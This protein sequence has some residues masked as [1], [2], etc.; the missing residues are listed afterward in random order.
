MNHI[1]FTGK[2]PII[3]E[4]GELVSLIARTDLK[5]NIAYPLSSKDLK[6]AM[7][8]IIKHYYIFY[9]Y[10]SLVGTKIS[11]IFTNLVLVN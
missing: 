1:K 2:L 11:V 3:N 10:T 7:L 9:I 8:F 4:N 5:K 6:Y